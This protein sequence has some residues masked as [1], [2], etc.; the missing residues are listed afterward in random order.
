MKESNG[1][2]AAVGVP[3]RANTKKANVKDPNKG[4]L[5]VTDQRIKKRQAKKERKAKKDPNQP[6]RPPSAFFVFLEDF[7]KSYKENHPDVKGVS[8]IGKAGG[9]KWKHMTDAE[10]QPYVTKALQRK[11]EYE[12][13]LAAYK[14]KKNDE[15]A[16][17]GESERSKSDMLEDDEESGEED[18]DDE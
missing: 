5:S 11:A 14:L 1:T 15:D 9:D 3:K 13:S 6:K 7:R 4:K 12:K 10:K 8:V 18:E 16:S 2:K 17:P